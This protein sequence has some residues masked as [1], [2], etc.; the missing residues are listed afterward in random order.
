MFCKGLEDTL[1]YAF[2][3]AKTKR[4]NVLSVEHLVYALIENVDVKTCFTKL[5]IAI[6]PIQKDI[7]NY[8]EKEL[9]VN[10]TIF[11]DTQPSPDFNG[12]YKELFSSSI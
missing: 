12:Y 11:T 5:S 1:T 3:M 7:E 10:Q 4:H 2:S 6:A 9:K 8:F